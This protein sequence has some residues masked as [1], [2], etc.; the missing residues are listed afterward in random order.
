M[1]LGSKDLTEIVR[2]RAAILN[3]F[4]WSNSMLQC[5][6]VLQSAIASHADSAFPVTDCSESVCYVTASF[7]QMRGRSGI[8]R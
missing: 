5:N 1:Y 4:F 6:T 2:V 3:Y 7:Q 8:Q